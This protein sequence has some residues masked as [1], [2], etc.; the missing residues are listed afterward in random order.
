MQ[1]VWWQLMNSQKLYICEPD[2]SLIFSGVLKK[3][4]FVWSFS[5]DLRFFIDAEINEYKYKI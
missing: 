1:V 5:Q 4:R 3:S 2:K